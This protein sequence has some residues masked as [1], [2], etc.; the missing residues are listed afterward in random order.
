MTRTG[1]FHGI[2]SFTEKREAERYVSRYS[3][4]I[5]K[6]RMNCSTPNARMMHIQFRI[7]KEAQ[8]PVMEVSRARHILGKIGQSQPEPEPEAE[9]QAQAEQQQLSVNQPASQPPTHLA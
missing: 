2:A 5:D 9:A 7:F 3:K 6:R 8:A 4:M 1:F